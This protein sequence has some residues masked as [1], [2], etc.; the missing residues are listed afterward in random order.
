MSTSSYCQ[1]TTQFPS[2][3]HVK[4]V[5]EANESPS[6]SDDETDDETYKIE[7]IEGLE[8]D[9]FDEL[10]LFDENIDAENNLNVGDDYESEKSV[11][12]NDNQARDALNSDNDELYDYRERNQKLLSA[13]KGGIDFDARAK[14][15]TDGGGEL[16]GVVHH[17][18]NISDSNAPNIDP[19]PSESIQPPNEPTE[20]VDHVLSS[21]YETESITPTQDT[22]EEWNIRGAKIKKN[23]YT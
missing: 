21:M 9:N 20:G 6:E 17:R 10:G 5:S 12:S 4:P 18:A 2:A 1:T 22:K 23:Y 8:D 15:T 11:E 7:L 16:R 13:K 3:A 19:S 14:L